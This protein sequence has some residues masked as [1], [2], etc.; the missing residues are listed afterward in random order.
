MTSI[1]TSNPAKAVLSVLLPFSKKLDKVLNRISSGLNGFLGR[2]VSV[3]LVP[4]GNKRL[5][6]FG[7]IGYINNS[8]QSC[9]RLQIRRPQAS[10]S[11]FQY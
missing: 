6:D 3:L 2:D 10:Q 8:P 7:A 4:V 9:L 11:L 1:V 5:R